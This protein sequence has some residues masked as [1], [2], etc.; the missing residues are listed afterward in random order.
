MHPLR[1]IILT[2]LLFLLLRFFI[3]LDVSVL[4]YSMILTLFI[5]IVDHTLSIFF[6]DNPLTREIKGM[7]K[8]KRIMEAM[9]QYYNE[10]FG[11]FKYFYL[12]NLPV[13]AIISIVTLHAQSPVLFLGLVFHYMCDIFEG[14]RKGNLEFWVQGWS[15][16]MKID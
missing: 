5:D 6:I 4:A 1:H 7:I 3:P 9:S 8:K 13:L 15:K 11:V 12:H 16:M 10:R 14:Y 2:S